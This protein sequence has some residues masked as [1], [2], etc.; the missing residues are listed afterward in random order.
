M[1]FVTCRS[2]AGGSAVPD[3][4]FHMERLPFAEF[5]HLQGGAQIDLPPGWVPAPDR[6]LRC[7]NRVEAMTARDEV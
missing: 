4:A 7:M 1:K 6:Y 5:A 3:A 2:R